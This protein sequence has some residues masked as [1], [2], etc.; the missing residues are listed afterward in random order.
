MTTSHT[1]SGTKPSRAPSLVHILLWAWLVGLT[2]LVFVAFQVTGDLAGQS[3]LDKSLQRLQSLEARVA[4]IAD[5]N[6]VLQGRPPSATAAALQDVRQALD[7]RA[8]QLEQALTARAA[9]E[10]VVALRAEL[11]QL[12]AR[13]STARS[14]AV[15]KPRPAQPAAKASEPPIL[16]RVIGSELRAGQRS[17]SIATTSGELSGAQ[18]QVLLPGDTVGVWRLEEIDRATAVFRAG[19]QTRRL[20]IP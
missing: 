14:S 10:D 13:Q 2:A 18:I 9:T 16:F 17:V 11:A 7:A 19:E 15:S 4:E 1:I 5:A 20:A 3:Q 6:R 8:D 12:K